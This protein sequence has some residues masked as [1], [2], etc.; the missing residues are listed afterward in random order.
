MNI[1]WTSDPQRMMKVMESALPSLRLSSTRGWCRQLHLLSQKCFHTMI[2]NEDSE[3][4]KSKNQ[5]NLPSNSFLHTFSSVWLWF[6][7]CA[8]RILYRAES[9]RSTLFRKV[10]ISAVNDGWDATTVQCLDLFQKE[11]KCCIGWRKRF[12]AD[13]KTF[14]MI[15]VGNWQC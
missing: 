15:H 10:R 9:C 12:F 2:T 5:M 13:G 3:A 6:P 8:L 14:K 7:H 4:S 1:V 11:T